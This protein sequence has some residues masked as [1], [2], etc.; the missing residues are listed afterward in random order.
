MQICFYRHS[1]L[2]RGGD[3]MVVEYA[4]YLQSRGHSVAIMA[5]HVLTLFK[6]QAEILRISKGH[7]KVNTI[8]RTLFKK[9]DYDIIIADIIVMTFL[10]S[11]RNKKRVLYFAQDYNE[12]YYKNPLMKLFVRAVY[13]YCLTIRKIP[14]IAVSEDLGKLLGRRFNASVTVVENGVDDKIFFPDADR[15]LMGVKGNRKAVLV[16]SQSD[17][18]KG[19]DVAVLVLSKFKKE[20]DNGSLAVWAVGEKI[21]VPFNM[22]YF[23]YVS[24]ETLRK[25]LSCADVLLYPSRHEGM[26]L[27]VLEAMACGCPVVTTDAVRF[28]RNNKDALQCRIDDINSLSKQ[29]EILLSSDS[30]RNAI[31]SEAFRSVR[32]YDIRLARSK[33]ESA[34]IQFYHSRQA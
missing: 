21:T 5:N 23:G 22:K 30:S 14:V 33:F 20:I 24:P 31:R 7:S 16:F 32:K 2:N 12:T 4:N 3:K 9:W 1:L 25:I 10:L 19:F 8:V 28:V 13:F 17:Y 15:E 29:V 26:G 6:P 34:L 27:F 18:R 11:I